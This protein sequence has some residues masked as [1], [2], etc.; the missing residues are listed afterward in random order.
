MFSLLHTQLWYENTNVFNIKEQI[1]DSYDINLRK[2][3]KIEIDFGIF[4]KLRRKKEVDVFK[5][6]A[7]GGQRY[8]I[9]CNLFCLYQWKKIIVRNIYCM[10]I[11]NNM[12]A[13]IV[14]NILFP[15]YRWCQN[16]EHNFLL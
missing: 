10:M 12:T 2:N 6:Y 4:L 15:N 7:E 14:G 8:N 1:L 3:L 11:I 5:I 16:H 9:V 13:T